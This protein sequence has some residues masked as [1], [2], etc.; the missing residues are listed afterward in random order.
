MR[1]GDLCAHFALACFRRTE[2]RTEGKEGRAGRMHG[3][4]FPWEMTV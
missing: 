2:E 1:F 3:D 4:Q